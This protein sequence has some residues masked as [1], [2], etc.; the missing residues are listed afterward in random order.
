VRAT[1]TFQFTQVVVPALVALAVV[2][3]TH[4]FSIYRDRENRRREQ[5]LEY[6]VSAFRALSKANHHPRLYE[7]ANEVE[8]AV[9]DLQL[10]GTPEQVRL[11]Q[12][13]A[14]DLGTNEGADIDMRTERSSAQ[15][16]EGTW[17]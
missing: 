16:A 15:F 7:I 13:F 2:S 1:Y 3:L 4:L 12:K 11:A 17:P 14:T 5:R 8:Q 9:V 6:L 10:F